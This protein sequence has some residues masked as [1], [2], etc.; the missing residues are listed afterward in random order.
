MDNA[1]DDDYEWYSPV[2]T[3]QQQ[4][5]DIQVT[6]VDNQG[7]LQEMIVLAMILKTTNGANLQSLNTIE[8][9]TQLL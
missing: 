9:I 6:V 8:G 1:N 5:E 7:P 3:S 4:D 2:K